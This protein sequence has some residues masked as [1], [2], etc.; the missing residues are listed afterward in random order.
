M[1]LKPD[2]VLPPGFRLH[3][4]Q[5]QSLLGDGGF[6]ITY[7]GRDTNL[8]QAV[9]IKEY[10]PKSHVYRGPDRQ[11][12]PLPDAEPEFF[13]WG[14]QRFLEEARLLARFRHP[15]IVR[16]LSVFESL[17][18]AF[19]VMELE[20]GDSL[21]RAIRSGG[22]S[23][24]AVLLDLCLPVLDG[25]AM[26]HEAGFIHRDIKPNNI[27]LR[28]GQGPV[29]ID[30]GS[31]RRPHPGESTELTAI[32]SRGYAPFEQYDAGNEQR[33]G[34]WTDIYAMAATL[35]HAITGAPPAD[36]LARGM[37]MLDGEPDPL[38]PASELASKR[39]S[40]RLLEA[41][42][43]GLAFRA[44]DRPQSVAEW[45][46]LF[47][48]HRG[49]RAFRREVRTE[50]V[51]QVESG[52]DSGARTA[53]NPCSD[54]ADSAEFEATT[55][56]GPVTVDREYLDRRMLVV[57]DDRGARTLAR[58]VLENL[59]VA[60]VAEAADGAEALACF[61]D[62]LAVPDVVLCDLEMSPM[63]GIE[64]LRHL[65]E[66]S[67][68]AAL[69]LIGE[70]DERMLSAVE[71]LASRQGLTVLGSV[72]K[73]VT[74]DALARVMARLDLIS[75]S[76]PDRQP[77]PELQLSDAD[78]REGIAADSLE[79]VYLPKVC[80]REQELLGAE[81][82]VR[83]PVAG[84]AGIAAGA[85]VD[86]V[87]ALGLADAFTD[88]VLRKALAQAG[89]WRATGLPC[90]L[91]VN[92][93][94]ASLA[95]LDLPQRLVALAQEE[96]VAP[97]DVVLEVA[98]LDFQRQSAVP[99]EVL[100]RLR[101]NGVGVSLD[102]FGTGSLNLERLRYIPFTELKVD[103]SIVASAGEERTSRV[104]LESSV[105]LARRLGVSVVA[106][107]VADAQGIE[108]VSRLGFD[109]AQGFGI[110]PPMCGASLREWSR[111]WSVGR[112]VA[113]SAPFSASA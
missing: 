41:V 82:L 58:R 13:R 55:A 71:H 70:S 32:V 23:G 59:G 107:G 63:D 104:I 35:Y 64:L 45:L 47:P 46:E 99:M 73:P 15:H 40:R 100:A 83:W 89:E 43:H 17:G 36:A 90:I 10:F 16:V 98:E 28:P 3:W 61:D 14:L 8:N 67:A 75:V 111:D 112:T 5:L 77:A 92:M 54:F 94:A 1:G 81:A 65:A 12:L 105:A 2:D 50:V 101:L 110:S 42:D 79:L 76:P 66:R 108:M 34:P 96:G 22:I 9:A 53:I 25:L 21:G 31:A 69:I 19:M 7:L 29:L 18:T 20:R 78:L 39:F 6:G 113:P 30:F 38:A 11:L 62:A 74:P 52:L 102:D 33:Q 60:H 51:D 91:S 56:V 97:G 87:A 106:E 44:D 80:L 103:R 49:G 86:R 85:L 93:F 72:R 68:R 26:V 48:E 27:L 95:R 88:Q 84:A 57:D 24:D 109:T 37:S 4:Y